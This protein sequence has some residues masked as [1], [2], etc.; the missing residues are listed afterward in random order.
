M[1]RVMNERQ[2]GEHLKAGPRRAAEPLPPRARLPL[3]PRAE[4]EDVLVPPEEVP[5]PRRARP[6][7][8]PPEEEPPADPIPRK[9]PPRKE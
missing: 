5:V 3:M 6:P 9:D 1:T 7:I 2:Y 4:G 8:M